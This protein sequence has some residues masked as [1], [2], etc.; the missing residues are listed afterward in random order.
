VRR[1]LPLFCVAALVLTGC[2]RQAPRFDNLVVV[3]VDTLRSDHLPSYG[4]GRDTAPT[5]TRLANEGVQLQGY[6]VTSWTKPSVASLLTGLHP[7]RHQAISRS[8]R[9]PPEAPYL[10]E[11]LSR[12]GVRTAAYIGNLNVGRKWGFDRGIQ[13]Y[14]QWNG[15]RKVD[16]TRVTTR[17]LQVA[18]GLQPPYFLYVHY[19]DPHDPYRPV[20]P[21]GAEGR[22]AQG[23]TQPR[24]LE[25]RAEPP[26][27]EELQQLRD[28][29]DGEIL[30]VDREIERLLRELRNRGLLERTLVVVTA[31]H[32]EE[33]GE[34]GG[35]THGHTLYEEVLQVPFL[36][37]SEEG[38]PRR[39]SEEVFYQLDFAPTMLE[40]LGH[41]VPDGMD[42]LPRWRET[43]NGRSQEDRDLFFHLDLEGRGILGLL[44]SRRKLLHTNE[45]PFNRLTDLARD[46]REAGE[47]LADPEAQRRLLERLIGNHNALAGTALERRTTDL[48]PSLRRSL[49]ALGYLQ[50]DTPQHELE[51]RAIPPRLSPRIGLERVWEQRQK[52]P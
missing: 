24:R 32:G 19:V 29:Y 34:H 49:A 33:F 46:P 50:V 44:S 14:D 26:T 8:D 16:G 5:L 9:L 42:G 48:D 51:A 23:Y 47:P 17:A 27:P 13:V 15:A 21:W 28:Q 43:V 35:L 31:D 18:R 6:A 36:L 2:G 41:P 11:L 10:P 4:Y 45:P 38:L 52:R 1:L 39:R 25:G 7:Q 12:E 30:E 40:A 3:M 20:R 22:P 37:W